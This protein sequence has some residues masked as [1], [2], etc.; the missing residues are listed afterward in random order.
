M[1]IWAFSLAVQWESFCWVQIIGFVLLL[2]GSMVYNQVVRI[3]GFTYP[4]AAP[5]KEA[6]LDD[7]EGDD[8][9]N[10]EYYEANGAG[11]GF[12]AAPGGGRGGYGRVEA[13][14]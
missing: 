8:G 3:P 9:N 11:Q 12:V 5:S 2:S 10:Y 14:I 1:V 13:D 6:L 7:E 4:D